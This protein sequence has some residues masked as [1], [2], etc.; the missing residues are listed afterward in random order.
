MSVILPKIAFTICDTQIPGK[1]TLCIILLSR[2]EK[3]KKPQKILKNYETSGH[4]LDTIMAQFFPL[5]K[6]ILTAF[7][8]TFLYTFGHYIHKKPPLP[9]S[10]GGQ[11]FSQYVYYY[12]IK[13]A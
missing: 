10:K 3:Y 6:G 5:R 7:I 8:V 4:S 2:R 13:R 1:L 11:F 12:F 9:L